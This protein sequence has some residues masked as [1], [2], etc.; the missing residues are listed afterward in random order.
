MA[1]CNCCG[2]GWEFFGS[3]QDGRGADGRT[4]LVESKLVRI[5]DAKPVEAEISHRPGSSA[6]IEGVPRR[7]KH[8][9]QPIQWGGRSHKKLMYSKTRAVSLD[10]TKNRGAKINITRG[11][12]LAQAPL[13][14]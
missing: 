6:D 4:S 9:A 1:V 11:Q 13:V 2:N 8:D 5:D 7:D 12:E 3:C 10:R 14:E